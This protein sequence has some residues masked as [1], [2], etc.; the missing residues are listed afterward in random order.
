MQ[1]NQSSRAK[2]LCTQSQETMSNMISMARETEEDGAEEAAEGQ[3]GRG[4]KVP[5]CYF[6][7]IDK[8]HSTNECPIAKQKKEE[9]EKQSSEPP[10]SVNYTLGGT[11]LGLRRRSINGPP[12]TPRRM[13]LS[14]YRCQLRLQHNQLQPLRLTIIAGHEVRLQKGMIQ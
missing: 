9:M 14:T 1:T 3:G 12:H 7:G 5:I 8:G 11:K 10:K 2:S 4:P 6:H 13:S